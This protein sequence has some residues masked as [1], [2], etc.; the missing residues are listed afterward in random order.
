MH[1]SILVIKNTGI[2]PLLQLADDINTWIFYENAPF[3]NLK[4]P[5]GTVNP[6]YKCLFPGRDVKGK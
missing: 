3:E 1:I 6:T 2:N 4:F 5:E